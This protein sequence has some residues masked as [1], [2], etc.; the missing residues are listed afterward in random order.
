MNKK[1]AY[2]LKSMVREDQKAVATRQK[3]GVVDLRLLN[4][5]TK[6]MREIVHD[7]GWPTVS[8]VGKEGAKNAWLLVQHAYKSLAFQKKCLLLMEKTFKDS[9]DEVTPMHIAFLTDRVRVNE[10][11]PQKFGTQFYTN[12]KEDLK[13][14]PIRDKKNV[15][16]R[17]AA[18]GIEPLADYIEAAKSFKPVAIKK[19]I[20]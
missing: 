10:N 13:L 19:T 6:R 5:H 9:P 8:S 4:I 2:E 7:F 16:K 18:F 14:W 17:R 15:D 20:R 12:G 11:K 3:K 1:L